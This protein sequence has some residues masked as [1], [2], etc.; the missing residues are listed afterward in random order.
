MEI[1]MN[2]EDM[3][4]VDIPPAGTPCIVCKGNGHWCQA[5]Q[6]TAGDSGN[7]ICDACADGLECDVV[8]ARKAAAIPFQPE[9]LDVSPAP[10]RVI[11]VEKTVV[12]NKEKELIQLPAPVPTPVLREHNTSRYEAITQRLLKLT[13]GETVSFSVPAGISAKEYENELLRYLT[14][15]PQTKTVKW[16]HHSDESGRRLVMATMANLRPVSKAVVAAVKKLDEVIAPAL[17]GVF[18]A[19]KRRGRPPGARSKKKEQKVQASELLK[20]GASVRETMRETGLAK[21]TVSTVRQE[22]G[23]TEKANPGGSPNHNT[24]F[25]AIIGRIIQLE[26]GKSLTVDAPEG[27][28][29]NAFAPELFDALV[30][31]PKTEGRTW[32]VNTDHKIMKV[33]VSEITKA[34][35]EEV[36]EESR[37]EPKAPNI[38]LSRAFEMVMAELRQGIDNLEDVG[39]DS[40][41]WKAA[42]K[43]QKDIVDLLHDS[44]PA[45]LGFSNTGAKTSIYERA[46][47]RA[48]TELHIINL[49]IQRLQMRRDALTPM[50]KAMG[51]NIAN[52]RDT[53]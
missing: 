1:E 32:K 25:G 40:D 26:P 12:V 51:E 17:A 43:S 45:F 34:E 15:H 16:I 52:E 18:S 11:S 10:V 28:T 41:D 21:N 19:P 30:E 36:E 13:P 27:I 4:N 5:D 8:K 29:L 42:M 49:E 24:K 47:E 44:H 53:R 38:T 22:L 31:H 23:I 48:K 7:G 14:N 46:M 3:L 2:S 37:K 9:R 33:I 20:S 35:P 39:D 50:L 6:Y